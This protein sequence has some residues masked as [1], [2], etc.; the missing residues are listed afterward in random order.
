MNPAEKA[1]TPAAAPARP[2]QPQLR[3]L[4]AVLIE[5]GWVRPDEVESA[6]QEAER[7]GERLG[8]ILLRRGRVTDTQLAQ[9]LAC[10]YQMPWTELAETEV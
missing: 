1:E 9:A 4:G 7:T 6:A 10:A 8:A 5:R 2:A 3:G